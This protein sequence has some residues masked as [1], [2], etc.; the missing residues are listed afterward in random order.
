MAESTWLSRLNLRMEGWPVWLGLENTAPEYGAR[1]L[2][3]VSDV[4]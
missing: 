4:V 2:D 3:R 1:R